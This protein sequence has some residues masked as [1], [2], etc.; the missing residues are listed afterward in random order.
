MSRGATRLEVGTRLVHD[1][2]MVEVVEFAARQ[3]GTDVVL[4]SAR[5]QYLRVS[6][7][8][9]L[10]S[11]RVRIVADGPGPSGDGADELA[12]ATL[13][14]LEEIDSKKRDWLVE[15]AEHAR[16]VCTGYKSGS[17]EL[18]RE[19]EPRPGYDPSL[20]QMA[21]YEAKA[22]ELGVHWRTVYR[23]VVATRRLGEAGLAGSIR[24]PTVLDRCD[25]RWVE[26]MA[27]ILKEYTGQSKP[28]RK[29]VLEQ[30][31][32]RVVARFGEGAVEVPGR[33]KA[34]D[35]LTELERQHPTFR[36][37]TKHNRDIAARPRGVFGRLRPTRPGE[38][39]LMDTTRLDV[40]ALDPATLRWINCELTVAMD[41]Y[42][43]CIVGARLTPVSTKAVDAAAV[44]FQAYR[45]LPV[46]P[47]WPAEAVWPEHG[48]PR[49]VVLDPSAID[50][51]MAKAAGPAL[52]PEAIV[53]DHGKIYVSEHMRSVCARMGISIQPVRLRTGRD[54]GPI[55][56]FFRT[57]RE[58]L[59]HRLPG[60]KGQDLFARGEHPE[61]E[62]FYYIDELFDRI[63]QWVAATYHR[64]PHSSLGDPGIKGLRMSPAQMFEHGVARAGYIEVPRDPY[65]ALE[66]LETQWRTIQPYGV[67]ID[68][69]RYNGEGLYRDGRPSPYLNGKWPIQVNPDDVDHAY[70]R[71]LDRKWHQLDWE[72]AAER[73][74]PL[75]E[76]ALEFGRKLAAERF[77]HPSDALAVKVLLERWNLGQGMTLAERRMALRAARDQAAFA[78]ALDEPAR[79]RALSAPQQ[80]LYGDDDEAD[81]EEDE[82]GS[83]LEPE[84]LDED[85]F[86]AEALEDL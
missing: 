15:R 23:W 30:A 58:D 17:A 57:L 24:V 75:S 28:M 59:L 1:G 25:V 12:S 52:A 41:W 34:Y 76:D 31:E 69:R 3:I 40:Y 43:R 80:D 50:G 11:E 35:A 51:P 48:I 4:R 67:E 45:P 47:H 44:L 42:T 36:L 72:H 65:L 83:E 14:L 63:R 54:K 10:F 20:P 86:Y 85:A 46:L 73:D 7:K 84:D 70:F 74:F 38:Y 29:T 60:Y 55:E 27:E 39:V 32:A 53:I 56:R 6:V 2:E 5:G 77:E 66:F 82:G 62:A 9:L 79:R 22:A 37:S 78:I 13:S 18:A 21:R 19:G 49:T 64:R 61:R 71:D 81:F 33:T 16:E 26:V 8:E 68:G